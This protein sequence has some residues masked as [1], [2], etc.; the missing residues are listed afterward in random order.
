MDPIILQ[1]F[2]SVLLNFIKTMIKNLL[3]EKIFSKYNTSSFEN[4]IG[5]ELTEE[6]RVEFRKM[7]KEATD[8]AEKLLKK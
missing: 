2:Y 7:I 8:N 3:Q 1:N 6:E 4:V 5:S